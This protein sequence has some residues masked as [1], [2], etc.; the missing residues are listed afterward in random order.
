VSL[1]TNT[2][3]PAAGTAL[4]NDVGV[5]YRANATGAASISSV[6]AAAT[7]NATVVKA[8]AGRLIGW[9]LQNTTASIVYVKMHNQTTTP[10]AGAAVAFAIPIPA[11]GKSEITLA[12]GIAFTT[13]IGYTTVTGSANTDATAVG[14][15]AIIG[16]LHFA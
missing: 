7:T 3:I 15:G 16:S 14:A 2:P 1:A 10:T 5:Q 12:A 4:S 6:I 13:G 11:N 9:Q 8:S